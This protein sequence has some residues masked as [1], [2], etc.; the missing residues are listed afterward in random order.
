M[1]AH[2]K[3]WYSMIT[4]LLIICLSASN[5]YASEKEKAKKDEDFSLPENV[6]SLSKA[7][8]FPN[9]TE[10]REMT[11]PSKETK[12]LLDTINIAID[13]SELI[14]LLN[15]TSI[16]PSP[17]GIGYNASIYLGRWPLTYQ[18]ESTTVIWDYQ[19]VNR[20]ELNNFGGEEVQELRYNQKEKTEIKGA[21]TNKISN[22][23]VVKQM[24]L[25]KSKDKTKL[26]LSFTAKIGKNTK[27]DN[28]YNIPVKKT[29][30]LDAFA[31][32]I[33]EKGQVIFG[34]V[35]IRLKGTGKEIEIKNVTKQG[36][37][38]WIPIQDH[39]SLSFQLK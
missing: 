22:S 17:I 13:N 19:R 33:N 5:V 16:N 36:I 20:N 30:F 2:L 23:D 10:D 15:E 9:I 3:K 39:V 35:Y 25:D 6:I 8:T 38:A 1:T 7:N 4:I 28:L 31:P 21:L 14:V 11:E 29:G 32:A 37:G 27:L 34:E 18:S 12:E 24:M 26:P